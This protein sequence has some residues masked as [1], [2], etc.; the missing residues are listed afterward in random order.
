MFESVRNKKNI[1]HHPAVVTGL[2]YHG[3][4]IVRSLGR[5]G[6]TVFGLDSDK[7]SVGLYS[8][9]CKAILCPHVESSEQEHLDFLIRLSESVGEK[10]VLFPTADEYMFCYAKYED[11]LRDHFIFTGP[12][13]NLID[14]VARKDTLIETASS[15]GIKIPE[16]Y[17]AK[18]VDE[19]KEI[20]SKIP[21]PCLIKPVYSNSW[22]REPMRK[23]LG[24]IKKVIIANNRQELYDGYRL[25]SSI[26]PRVVISEYIH[27]EDSNYLEYCFYISRNYELLA[28]VVGRRVR[29][30]PVHFGASSYVEFISDDQVES[31]SMSFLK[32]IGYRG[33]GG[34]EYKKDPSGRLN[35]IEFN[36]RFIM[37]QP[38]GSNGTID[39]PSIAYY[40]SI[41]EKVDPIRRGQ[42]NTKWI[43][44]TRDMRAFIRYKKEG[45]LNL[46]QWIR[47]LRGK[48]RWAVFSFD[49]M[50]PFVVSLKNDSIGFIRSL[51]RKFL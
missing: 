2:Y 41:G 50:R 13:S 36:A 38:N 15:L 48:K 44:F 7:R 39:F 27:G 20:E 16:T 32:N 28:A 5:K 40:D 23:I 19:I 18:S 4:G 11:I 33:F 14:K 9:F 45:S 43:S 24:G 29:L 46:L 42:E 49:D 21:F 12:E 8:R 17:P 31:I 1:H 6:I 34:I 47:S 30:F 22:R 26:D 10:P 51:I 35:L 37:W 3:L 25:I